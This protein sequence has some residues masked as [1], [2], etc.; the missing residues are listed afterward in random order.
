MIVH[1]FDHF[2]EVRRLAPATGDLTPADPSGTGVHGHYGLL[3]DTVVVLYRDGEDLLLRIGGTLVPVDDSVS[4]GYDR[5]GNRRLLEVT[6]NATG[7][8]AARLAYTLPEPIVAPEDD[9]TP[10]AEAEDFDFG[11]FIANVANDAERRS[12]IYRESSSE[13]Q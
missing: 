1:S 2:G 5:V 7:A 10:F 4:I 12:A 9:P 8:V 3:G 11:L 13:P 6:D